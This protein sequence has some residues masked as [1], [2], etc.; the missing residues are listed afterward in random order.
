[1]TDWLQIFLEFICGNYPSWITKQSIAEA[2]GYSVGSGG[3]NNGISKLVNLG[4]SERG[5]EGMIRASEEMF[6][7]EF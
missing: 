5:Q 4:L 3:F 7:G 2:T 1:M 6:P